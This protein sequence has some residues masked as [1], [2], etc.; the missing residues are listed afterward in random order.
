MF[1]FCVQ[2]LKQKSKMKFRKH[3]WTAVIY[4]FFLNCVKTQKQFAWNVTNAFKGF[5]KGCCAIHFL[6]LLLLL[7]LIYI[8]FMTELKTQ[9][10]CKKDSSV[11]EELV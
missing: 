8:Y 9:N 11:D 4:L 10:V 1:L 6:L 2:M 7:L 5:L 3:F